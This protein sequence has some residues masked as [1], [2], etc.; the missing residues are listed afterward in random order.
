MK[1]GYEGDTFPLKLAIIDEPLEE[2]VTERL[3][4][5][6]SDRPYSV[7]A[8]KGTVRLEAGVQLLGGPDERAPALAKL[9]KAA[10]LPVLGQVNGTIKVETD[11]GRFA[12][13]RAP[14]AKEAKAST[15][16][17][18]PEVAYLPFREPPR[19]VLAV[20]QSQGGVVAQG[21][22]FT[23]NGTVSEPKGL[24][25]MYV[26]VN[27]QKVYF[28][29]SD[30]PKNEPTKLSFTTDFPLKEGTNAVV[31]VARQTQDFSSREGL[32]PPPPS[33]G[34]GPGAGPRLTDGER[35]AALTRAAATRGR[36][37]ARPGALV[38]QLSTPHSRSRRAWAG[39]STVHTATSRP[40]RCQR[41]TSTRSTRSTAGWTASRPSN[42]R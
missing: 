8:R 7:E 14:D 37:A 18:T 39:S 31:V 9:R 20:D 3:N 6:L 41:S 12:F 11:K 24:L 17:T 16:P 22:R 33:G 15:K 30:S 29:T 10:I 36:P 23:L 32:D 19:I 5:P 4:L 1:K 38:M 34:R 35:R 13:V 25:D 28:K 2:F 21:D 26:L 27:D 40:L 42:G